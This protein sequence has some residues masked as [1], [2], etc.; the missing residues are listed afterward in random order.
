[1]DLKNL[2]YYPELDQ[3][4]E[5]EGLA[6]F[7]IGRVIQEHKE[8]YVVRAEARE[9]NGEITGNMR[10]SAESR[11]D[12]PAVGDWVAFLAM[13]DALAIIHRV[14]PR[15]TVL[16]RQAVG[17][18][19]EKQTIATNVDYALIMQA[20][21]HDFNPNRLDR[22][23]SICHAG[24]I[25]P[26]VLIS[27]LDL[28][29]AAEADSMEAVI[30][31]RNPD[32]PVVLFSSETGEGYERIQ[33]LLQP[34]KTYCCL[35]SSGVGK[36]TL[37]NKLLGGER[38]KTQTISDFSSKGRHTTSHRHLFVL[39]NA[40]LLIDTPGMREVGI[41]ENSEGLHLTFD[42]IAELAQ[43]CKFNNCTHTNEHGCAVLEALEKGEI[44]AG[45]LENY[46]KMEREQQHFGSTI[47][48]KRAKDKKQGKLY[49]SIM[50]NKKKTKY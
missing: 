24:R 13:D 50:A 42:R 34:G 10:Y 29:E 37:I 47:R 1:M 19:G 26:I 14:L 46:H 7:E 23:L 4:V 15:K 27:K 25:K 48:E 45:E 5:E 33:A 41:T 21:G 43:Q 31:S 11:A 9:Y 40:A 3:F 17:K 22:Y 30:K 12:F 44:E 36:S 8:R 49:K 35:G 39:D 6:G 28:V 38:M 32:L 16:E 20:A 18:F 2:G